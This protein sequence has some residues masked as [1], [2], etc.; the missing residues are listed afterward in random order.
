MKNYNTLNEKIKDEMI[1]F[2]NKLSKG[3]GK[4]DTH[5]I[6]DM[7]NGITSNNSVILSDIARTMNERP[8]IK[9]SVERIE[10][11]LDEYD[12]IKNIIE[13]NY[14]SLVKNYLNNRKL[15]FVDGGDI[16]KDKNTKFENMGWVL[17]GSDEHKVKT[18]YKLFEID[19]IDHSNQPISLVSE[20][21]SSL[22]E[23]YDSDNSRWLE[24]I[25]K[26]SNTYGKGT[27]IMDRGFDS[28]ILMDKIIKNGNDFIIRANK[29]ER[30]VYLNGDKTTI[31]NIAIR[32]KGFYKLDVNYRGNNHKLKVTAKT[33]KIKNKEA[34]DLENNLLTLVII[35]GFA[36]NT[37]TLNEAYMALITSR[38]VSSKNDVLQAVRDYLL[39]WRIE[40]NFRYKKQQFNLENIRI[41]KYN[42]LQ[43]MYKLLSM[44]MIF[45]NIINIKSIGKTVRKIKKQ[46]REKI[47]FWLYRISDGIKEV[48]SFFSD[49]LI[50][51]IYPKPRKRRRDLF[52]VMGVAFR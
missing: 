13:L 4:I 39:R 35:K 45:N 24:L 31:R 49:E 19:S 37:N 21:S 7:V 29:L 20:L 50:K 34:K 51:L 17:D 38:K 16:V 52:T 48:I 3:L 36:I 44:I 1:N 25:N 2:I 22:D 6:T 27:F 40:E 23:E 46:I 18:G 12:D 10:R 14:E 28:G 11:H 15:Y 8:N 47:I 42:R 41:R 32:C 43:V 9:K 26:T 33:I 5:F 30:Y